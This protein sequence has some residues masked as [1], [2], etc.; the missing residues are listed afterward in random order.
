MKVL[1]MTFITT[2]GTK[3]SIDVHEPDE[4]LT[5][6]KI[7]TAMQLVIAKNIFKTKAGSFVSIDSAEIV[8]TATSKIVVA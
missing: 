4:T 6:E 5:P 2:N 7:K 1:K 8:E 3:A